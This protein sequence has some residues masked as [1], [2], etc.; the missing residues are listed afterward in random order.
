[1]V[2]FKDV[3]KPNQNVIQIL[4]TLATDENAPKELISETFGFNFEAWE[5]AKIMY[6]I[7]MGTYTNV[8]KFGAKVDTLL[9]ESAKA[10][11]IS[12]EDLALYKQT[13]MTKQAKDFD[14]FFEKLQTG[15]CMS[16]IGSK[17]ANII[18]S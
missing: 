17:E 8:Q 4:N 13:K 16:I 1:M 6:A 14:Y 15:Y 12:D 2:K 7:R 11:G 18:D 9:A 10:N 5:C 3:V